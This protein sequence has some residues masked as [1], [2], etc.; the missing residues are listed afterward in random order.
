MTQV[1]LTSKLSDDDTE[2][3]IVNRENGLV[4][5]LKKNHVP[6]GLA[7]CK[8]VFCSKLTGK[9]NLKYNAVNHPNISLL[10][11]KVSCLRGFDFSLP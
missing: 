6:S 2:D 5:N 9:K 8:N 10:K 3:S 4:L 1:T 11:L 7:L